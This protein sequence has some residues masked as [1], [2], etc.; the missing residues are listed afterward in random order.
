MIICR[1]EN[2]RYKYIGER[3]RSLKERI[4]DHMTYIRT[5]NRNQAT[6]EHFNLP[7]H[8]LHDMEVMALEVIQSKDPC[9]EKK[10]KPT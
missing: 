3:G 1:K 9:I 10:E 6:G 7:G 5:K 4:S 8:G 2:W